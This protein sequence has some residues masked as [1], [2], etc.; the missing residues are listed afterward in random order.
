MQFEDLFDSGLLLS[1]SSLTPQIYPLPYLSKTNPCLPNWAV[2]SSLPSYEL[3]RL[4]GSSAFD[5]RFFGSSA[6]VFSLPF[7]FSSDFRLPSSAF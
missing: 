2:F 3:F 6:S 1:S 4:F 5:L 7:L